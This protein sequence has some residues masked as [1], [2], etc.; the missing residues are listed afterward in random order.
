MSRI[1]PLKSPFLCAN[2][3]PKKCRITCSDCKAIHKK[4]RPVRIPKVNPDHLID[5]I[6]QRGGMIETRNALLVRCIKQDIEGLTI[7]NGYEIWLPNQSAATINNGFSSRPI[8][9][10]PGWKVNEILRTLFI[11]KLRNG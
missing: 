8:A 5:I 10:V 4:H 3:G 7:P 6:I 1:D 11:D 9:H 2:G